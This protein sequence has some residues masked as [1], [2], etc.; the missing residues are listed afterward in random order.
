[1]LPEGGQCV[2]EQECTDALTLSFWFYGNSI[3][4]AVRA[5]DVSLCIRDDGL[6]LQSDGERDCLRDP[7]A[8]CAFAV[9]PVGSERPV[10]DTKN[11]ID[12]L[13]CSWPQPRC[14]ARVTGSGCLHFGKCRYIDK[15]PELALPQ[16]CCYP[17]L[18]VHPQYTLGA[19]LSQPTLD[20]GP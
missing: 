19:E 9:P 2:L 18:A 7:V 4:M 20:G 10:I 6:I 11:L 13:G 16:D 3:D 15:L 12:I 5:T 17:L 8:D 14:A 1:M